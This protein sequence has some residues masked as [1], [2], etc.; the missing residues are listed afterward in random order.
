MELQWNSVFFINK[1]KAISAFLIAFLSIAAYAE[2]ADFSPPYPTGSMLMQLAEAPV[3]PVLSM[4]AIPIQDA[5]INADFHLSLLPYVGSSPIELRYQITNAFVNTQT[6]YLSAKNTSL[7]GLPG[8]VTQ[9][10]V[11]PGDC[12]K[13]FVLL[14][15]ESCML[16]LL[17]NRKQ[18]TA[19][20]FAYGPQASMTVSWR[21]GR[22]KRRSK[23]MPTNVQ[24]PASQRIV[25]L[26][27]PILRPVELSVEPIAQA[28]LRYNHAT[29]AIEGTPTQTGVFR[30]SIRAEDGNSTTA[31]RELLVRV[32]VDPKDTPV[33]KSIVSLPSA[34]PGQ[35]YQQE[36]LNLL[37]PSPG[38]MVSNQIAF[39]IV[40]TLP[41]PSWLH[42]DEK[43][44]LLLTGRP[45]LSD[46]GMSHSLTL[47][48]VSNTGGESKPLTLQI[49]V[50]IDPTQKPVLRP[51][52][53]LSA[54]AG[55]VFRYDFR[56]D[57]SDPTEDG[58][59]RLYLD[60]VEPQAEWLKQSS[61]APLTLTGV[62]GEGDT[63]REYR[64]TVR[65]QSALG[66]MS[67][68]VSVRLQVAINP[69]LTPMFHAARP[70]L[71]LLCAGQHY[72]YDFVTSGD[73][74]P[75]Y[76]ELPYVIELAEEES[77]PNWLRIEDNRLIIDRVTDGLEPNQYVYLRI[78]NIP[79][80]RSETYALTLYLSQDRSPSLRI[81]ATPGDTRLDT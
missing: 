35:I 9:T 21:W 19:G 76:S 47:I 41:H 14:N 33:F 29:A 6:A 1:I 22:N 73:V 3:P 52:I 46:A 64:L 60:R 16:H 4:H 32:G 75:D 45:T 20:D 11:K 71:P 43:N 34:I 80:G 70:H 37:E 56:D 51:D 2:Q 8:G 40:P 66:G 13:H 63:G 77:N 50:A 59:L 67:E 15:D 81:L 48:A 61:S 26:L 55:S 44:P 62:P 53:V 65:A 58:G 17:V 57:I 12:P 31:K 68:P 36:L 38:F 25:D 72:E 39:R 5:R 69:S 28:G 78:R 18:Y 74:Y 24:A 79:G 27:A 7:D 42:I 10:I 30:F 49:P 54:T 23:T